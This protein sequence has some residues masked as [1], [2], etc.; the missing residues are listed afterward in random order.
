[1]MPT[2]F[3]KTLSTFPSH[4][5]SRGCRV[6]RLCGPP[7]RKFK[8]TR[9]LFVALVLLLT[10]GT[11]GWTKHSDHVQIPF[12]LYQNHVV[13][14]TGSLG[15]LEQRNLLIDT[16]T[17]PTV[18]DSSVAQE[19]GLDRTAKQSGTLS[20]VDGV[21]KSYYA[22]L[23]TMGFGPVHRESMTIAVTNLA[24]IREQI[25]VRVDA[26]I[27][28]DALADHNFQIDYESRKIS[29]GDVK[30]P[31]SSV[32]VAEA[33]RLLMVNA[34]LN[35]ETVKLMLDT[36]GSGLVL[37]AN[38]LPKSSSWL[39]LETT[40]KLSNLAGHSVLREIQLK[41]LRIGTT[42][43]DGSIASIAGAP[44]CC[45]VQG[46]LGVSALQF[47]RIVFDFEHRRVGFELRDQGAFEAL[48]VAPCGPSYESSLCRDPSTP[49]RQPHSNPAR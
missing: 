19:L 10:L 32:P 1:M 25:G 29:F 26:V 40:S 8:P 13:I 46:V 6:S 36:G 22:V 27:G 39:T 33:D 48:G 42:N 23:P 12:K 30:V 34:Q 45:K 49:S 18:V 2:R 37:F 20:V 15:G 21:V 35:G 16:G 11:G 24:W 47:K 41:E 31:K 38:E 43:L 44:T 7:V 17:N 3:R 28:W 14:V 9:L 5:T 4:N